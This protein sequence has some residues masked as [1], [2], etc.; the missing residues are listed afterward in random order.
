MKSQLVLLIFLSSIAINFVNLETQSATEEVIEIDYLDCGPSTL[1]T[2]VKNAFLKEI[3]TNNYVNSDL[4]KLKNWIVIVNNADC[5]QTL[6]FLF[7]LSRVDSYHSVQSIEGIWSVKFQ[8]GDVAYAVLSEWEESGKLWGFYP[9]KTS[10]YELRYEPNDPLYENQWYLD[11]N[12]QNNGTSGIDINP[13]YVWETYNGDEINIAIIDDGLDYNNPDLSPNFLSSLSYDYC[14]D[15]G[16]VM[17]LDSDDDGI[18]DWHGTAVAGVA[19]AKGNNNLGVTG[20]SY[21]S[22]LIGVRLIAKDCATELASDRMVARALNH[23]LDVVDIYTNSWGPESIGSVLGEI[24]PLALNALENGTSNGRNGLGS[25]YVWSAGNGHQNGD[26][27]NKDA[28]AN[29]RYTI[30]VGA[31]NWKGE[32]TGYSEFGSNVLV[33]APSSPLLSDSNYTGNDPAIFSTDVSGIAG[34]NSTDYLNDMGGTSASTPMVSGVIALMLEANPNL[35]WRDVQHIL[36]RTSKKIDSSNEGWFTTYIGRDYNHAYGYGLI[37]AENAVNLAKEWENYSANIDFT[38]VMVN[39][40]NI[41]V[42][43]I[44]SDANDLGVTSEVFVNESIDIETVEIKVNISHSWRGDLNFFLESP[45]GVVSE[46]VRESNDGSDHYRNWIFSSVVHW[47]ENS[48]G[49]WKLKVNDTVFGGDIGSWSDWN[50]TF[51]GHPSIDRDGDNL[52]DFAE[53]ILE[54]GINNPDSDN[55]GLNDGDEYY[56]WHDLNGNFHLTDLTRPDTDDDGVNDGLEGRDDNITNSITDP[57]DN[58]TD[59]DGLLDGCE[60]FGLDDCDEYVTDPLNVDTDSDGISDF[61]EIFAHLM[62]PSRH[63]SDPTKLDT[64][65]DGMPDLYE[66]ENGLHPQETVDGN[67]DWDCDGVQVQTE[68]PQPETRE[69]YRG[70]LVC[71]LINENSKRFTNYQEYLMGTNPND[72]DSD[73]DGLPDGWEYY[74]GL[75]P[76]VIDSHL[77]L[78][79]DTISNMH[80]YDNFLIDNSIFSK[81]NSDLRAYWKFDVLHP[82]FA[83]DLSTEANMAFMTNVNNEDSKP[84]KVEAKYTNGVYCDKDTSHLS[85]DSIQSTKFTEYTVQSWVKL[86]DYTNDTDDID[87]GTIVGTSTDGRTWLGIDSEGY[88]QFRVFAG[89]K[90]YTTPLKNESKAVLNEWYHVAATYSETNNSLRLYV[91]GT[92]AANESISPSHSIKT[93][94]DKNYICKSQDGDYLNGTV[95]NVAIWGRA[96]TDDEIRYFYERPLGIDD[97]DGD[98]FPDY[99]KFRVEDGIMTTNAN[100]ADTDG[101]GLSDN[102]ELYFGLDG[103]LTDP[104]NIDTDGDGL[105]DYQEWL[106]F[107][108]DPTTNDTDSDNVTDDIDVFPLDS[109]EWID[110]DGDGVGNN[111]DAFPLDFNA[112]KDSDSDGIADNYEDLNGN[113]IVDNG[114]TDYL[115]PDTDDDGYCDGLINVTVEDLQLCIAND[116]FP[117]DAGDWL[118]TDGDG[119]G[120][121]S[122]ACPEDGRDWLDTDLDGFCDN[123]DAFHENANEWKDSDSDGYGDNSDKY[124]K[125]ATRHADPIQK[126]EKK[127]PIGE[128]TLDLALPYIVLIGA[129]YFVFKFFRK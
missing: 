79:N 38:E 127:D 114:E 81:F 112:T 25:I 74:S 65:R 6:E 98:G 58:D 23:E 67:E 113:S 2:N 30:A 120:D 63:R 105:G 82:I 89:N 44:V 115:N 78:D 121:N 3:N 56:G 19:S 129:V 101:D 92:L 9:E 118:D 32:L 119:Y 99:L 96:F 17:P 12:G 71:V 15:D 26:N 75:D 90:L 72:S 45:N 73:L 117:T 40:G 124:P 46:L 66:L 103:Y 27:S 106:I 7:D 1:S 31:T 21:N 29:S 83:Y 10:R 91:N 28:Y 110:T 111:Q 51:Y 76:L 18:I 77:D 14:D 128:G 60:I 53:R 86:T 11:N 59:D 41:V 35:T 126:V 33:V 42:N 100:S 8:S 47:D 69:W 54:T 80:E 61:D 62:E 70:M 104:T 22:N 122:D 13:N 49:L 5:H 94:G 36:V 125:D 39:T 88:I 43:E 84:I 20:V 34:R 102:E 68:A 64:D 97:A 107:G 108:T 24:G 123:S 4:Y 57:N 48:F 50:M 52:S 95:D 55:D 87:F 109:S 116:L 85:V 93:A 16:D 37:D